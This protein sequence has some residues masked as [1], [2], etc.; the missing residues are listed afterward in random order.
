LSGR[1][2]AA[3][4]LLGLEAP[5][6]LA[7]NFIF[8]GSGLEGGVAIAI[9]VAL[10]ALNFLAIR[11]LVRPTGSRIWLGLVVQALFVIHGLAIAFVFA[12]IV[13]LVE[14]VLAAVTTVAVLVARERG[15]HA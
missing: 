15:R 4:I 7:G 13:G 6:W 3:V 12:Y 8:I 1:Q 2:V 14:L 10:M 5:M 11:A 9:I